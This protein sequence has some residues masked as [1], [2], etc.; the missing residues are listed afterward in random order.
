MASLPKHFL[1]FEEYLEIERQAEVKSEYFAGDMFLMAGAT[2]A[3]NI[4]CRNVIRTLAN[5]TL[6]R[7][8]Q[9]YPSDMRVRVSKLSKGSYPDVS[10][11]CGE[12]KFLDDKRDTLLNPMV[13][14]EVLF[15]STEAYDRGK[16]FEHYQQLESLVEYILISQTPYRIKQFT[17]QDDRT[18][19]YREFRHADEIVKLESVGC[20]LLLEDV[21]LKVGDSQFDS[22]KTV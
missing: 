10:I 22:S 2:E 4:I 17:R 15:D 13:I 3:H 16:K 1:T 14:I 8:C 19:T 11:V 9:V 6:E 12:R 5:Q 18:W 7:D 21:Y 20:T